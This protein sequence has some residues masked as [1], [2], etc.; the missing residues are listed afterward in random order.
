MPKIA[1]RAIF[2]C[3]KLPFSIIKDNNAILHFTC[4]QFCPLTLCFLHSSDFLSGTLA[5]RANVSKNFLILWPLGRYTFAFLRSV[6]PQG[7]QMR[8]KTTFCMSFLHSN[9]HS[10]IL[11]TLP[12]LLSHST[13]SFSHSLSL[14]HHYSCKFLASTS[15]L[16]FYVGTLALS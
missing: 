5:R 3:T 11:F 15:H 7:R 10:S 16:G 8:P 9:S 4:L 13:L 6:T 2:H 12:I 14:L 1:P